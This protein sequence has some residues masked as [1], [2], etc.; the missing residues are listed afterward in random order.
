MSILKIAIKYTCQR[1]RIDMEN[2][3]EYTYSYLDLIRDEYDDVLDKLYP[4]LPEGYC[5]NI[6]LEYGKKKEDS[7]SVKIRPYIS[8]KNMNQ[9]KEEKHAKFKPGIEIGIKINF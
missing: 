2:K 4:P 1:K 8:I 3:K 6:E 9:G 7:N 5:D